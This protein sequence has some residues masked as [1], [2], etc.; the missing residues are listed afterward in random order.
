MGDQRFAD[1]RAAGRALGEQLVGRLPPD[2]LV[3]GLPRGGVVVAAEVA[4]VLGAPLD[5][6]VVR[7]LGLPA[8][9]ELAM[10]AIAAV[11]G[12]IETVRVDPVLSAAAVDAGTF[13][14]VGRQELAELRRREAAYREGRPPLA[15]S[16]RAV[17]LVDDG[18][19]T[20]ATVR[21]AVSAVRAGG[22]TSVTVAVPVG[23][24]RACAA[25]EPLVDG[26]VCLLA[27]RGF[28]AVGQAYADFDQTTDEEVRDALRGSPD[29]L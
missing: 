29:P 27:P 25:L 15:V 16:G 21:A 14:E 13:D 26:L 8:Q 19:A 20:G 12:S 9:P 17:V 23:S 1:R 6:L 22:A 2:P 4:A 18:V 7:K 24:P 5:V 11:G 28:R 10:G 3:L